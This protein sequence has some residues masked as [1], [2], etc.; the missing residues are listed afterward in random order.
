MERRDQMDQIVPT[1]HSRQ[2]L[3]LHAQ[4]VNTATRSACRPRRAAAAAAG[5]AAA[6]PSPPPAPTPTRHVSVGS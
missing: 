4:L 6:P 1:Y 3:Y 5:P 2:P